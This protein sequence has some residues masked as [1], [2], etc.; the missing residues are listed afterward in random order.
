MIKS[1]DFHDYWEKMPEIK[2]YA[3]AICLHE[4][5][6]TED[7]TRKGYTSRVYV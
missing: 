7:F 6:F 3:D 5:I 4:A 1:R 2:D